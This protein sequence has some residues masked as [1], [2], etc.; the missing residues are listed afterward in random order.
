M[1]KLAFGR[2]KHYKNPGTLLYVPDR[3]YQDEAFPFQDG[4]T[5]KI[6]IEGSRLVQEKAEW[7][8]LIDW[9]SFSDA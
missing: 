6:R 7:W 1:A 3:V 2:F 9:D 5:V 4:E 8:E